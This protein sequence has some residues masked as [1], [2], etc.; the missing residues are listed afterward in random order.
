MPTKLL[1]ISDMHFNQIQSSW[2]NSM[3]IENTN[4]EE[5]ERKYKEAGYERP[6]IV[7]WNVNGDAGNIPVTLRDKNI[8]LISGYSPAIIQSVMKGEFLNPIQVM[9]VTVNSERYSKIKIV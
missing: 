6:G 8:A 3:P 7:F 4:F 2:R 5:I 1:I 9:L